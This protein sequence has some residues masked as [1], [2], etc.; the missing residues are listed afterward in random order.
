M[1]AETTKH[2]RRS[3]PLANKTAHVDYFSSEKRK[4]G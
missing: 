4:Q 1:F 2:V 3:F